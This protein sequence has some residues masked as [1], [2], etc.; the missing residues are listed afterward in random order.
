VSPDSPK[1]WRGS[2]ENFIDP[3]ARL[4]VFDIPNGWLDFEYRKTG[5]KDVLRD[6]LV[7][8]LSADIILGFSEIDDELFDRMIV[9]VRL[10]EKGWRMVSEAGKGRVVAAMAGLSEHGIQVK[11]FAKS[12]SP[13]RFEVLDFRFR[14]PNGSYTEVTTEVGRWHYGLIREWR[15]SLP[16]SV[17]DAVH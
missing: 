13:D 14:R 11:L 7:W 6:M 10:A 5:R 1:K 9:P 3:N 8:G 15:S 17:L 12:I 4:E 16:E 2:V